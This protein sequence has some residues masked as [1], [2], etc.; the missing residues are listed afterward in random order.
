MAVEAGL[1]ANPAGLATSTTGRPGD[2]GLA[3]AIATLRTQ[4]LPSGE[5]INEQYLRLVARI[6]AQS[7]EAISRSEAYT[8]TLEQLTT[9]RESV[10]GVSLDEEM[11]NMTRF[12]QA[13][14]AA[15]RVATAIDEMI[16][17]VVSGMG[18][19]GR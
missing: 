19:V 3:E 16:E 7:R 15:A 17:T 2:N 13:Y 5:T 14:N 9:Q 11:L 6:G 1:V 8:L 18:V 10:S 4:D 12:Q